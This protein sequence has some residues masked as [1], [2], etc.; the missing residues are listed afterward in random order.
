[1]SSRYDTISFLSDFGLEDEFVGVVH[2]VIRQIAPEVRVIDITHGIPPHDVRAGGLALARAAQYLAPGVVVAVVDPGVGT[3]RRPIAVEVGDGASVLVGPDNGLLAPAVGLCG[4]ATR[5]V[6]LVAPEYRLPTV[7][8]TFDGR[9]VF[10]PAAAHLCNGV[11]LTALGPELDPAT[12]LPGILPVARMEG[13][14][15]VT[16]VLW[17]DRFGNVQLDV[18]PDEIAGLGEEFRLR[19]GTE[20]R[21]VVRVTAFDEIPA[22]RIGALVDSSGLVALAVARGSA[23]AVLGV[24][25]GDEIRLVP[26]DADEAGGV[27]TPVDLSPRP[28]ES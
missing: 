1:M 12:L 18:G 16:E 5:A 22:G 25:E 20:S 21:T 10:A 26:L 13:D 17:I 19:R 6:E 4:G 3:R 15:L 2:S 9:D 14:E 23:A 28:P 27:V 7:G 11:P 8:G 24:T